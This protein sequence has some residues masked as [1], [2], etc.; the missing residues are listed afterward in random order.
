MSQRQ[1]AKALGV[2]L[3]KTNYCLRAVVGKGWVK[4]TN[5]RNS[6]NKVAYIYQL[7]PRGVS[8]KARITRRFLDRKVQEYERLQGE[9]RQL[10]DEVQASAEKPG[11]GAAGWHELSILRISGPAEPSALDNSNRLARTGRPKRP[12]AKTVDDREIS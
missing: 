1:L 10:R 11:V 4:A 5:F 12:N 7:T 9:I 8:A 6:A 2:S 3:G